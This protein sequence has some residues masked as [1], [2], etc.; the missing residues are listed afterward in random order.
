MNRQEG[1]QAVRQVGMQSD[2]P[3]FIAL[4]VNNLPRV[5]SSSDG[6]APKQLQ[7][8]DYEAS[9]GRD[10]GLRSSKGIPSDLWW[11][12][13]DPRGLWSGLV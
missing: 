12:V 13:C 4:I 5:D 7:V 11:C 10:I 1:K 8:R 6:S 3:D 9:G 2:R